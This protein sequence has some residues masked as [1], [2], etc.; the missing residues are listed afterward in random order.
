[1]CIFQFLPQ[2]WRKPGFLPESAL[3]HARNAS[4]SPFMCVDFIFEVSLIISLLLLV[5]KN[6][7][8]EQISKTRFCN[9]L[10][11]AG[12]YDVS[13]G[14]FGIYAKSYTYMRIFDEKYHF[15]CEPC[16][17]V[18][19]GQK[20]TSAVPEQQNRFRKK[21]TVPQ[22]NSCSEVRTVL[23]NLVLVSYAPLHSHLNFPQKSFLLGKAVVV[24]A[25]RNT[26]ADFLHD[27]G[28]K[29]VQLDQDK[30]MVPD[31]SVA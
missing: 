27:S 30:C 24:N 22:Q 15:W 29:T 23:R 26:F 31:D 3:V 2:K 20:H 12:S 1:M 21:S 6:F 4:T 18:C 9:Y 7:L 10:T 5:Q 17:K 14:R 11:I 25:R 28:W 13:D 8:C 16:W 19:F